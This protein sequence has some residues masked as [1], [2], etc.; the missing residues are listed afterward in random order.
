VFLPLLA[1]TGFNAVGKLPTMQRTDRRLKLPVS[2]A[3]TPVS[4]ETKPKCRARVGKSVIIRRSW[5][6]Q[7]KNVST[8]FCN[9]RCCK[10]KTYLLFYRENRK[11]NVQHVR[12]LKYKKNGSDSKDSVVA[13]NFRYSSDRISTAV[14]STGYEFVS[15]QHTCVVDTS[16]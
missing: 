11:K 15:A 8:N 16:H 2:E 7:K 4:N 14:K 13:D 6:P 10:K 12:H 5:M 9:T 1:G 3:P